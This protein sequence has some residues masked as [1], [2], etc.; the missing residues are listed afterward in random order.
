[1]MQLTLKRL[2]YPGS[3]RGMVGAGGTSSSRQGGREEVWD[4]NSQR[5]D[6]EE[7]KIWSIKIKKKK[8]WNKIF[9][10]MCSQISELYK[11]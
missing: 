4:G 7:N 11:T 10:R 6:W 8:R 1:M 5:V 2:D 3:L 9:K